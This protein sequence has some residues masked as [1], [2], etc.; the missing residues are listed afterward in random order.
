MWTVR[1]PLEGAIECDTLRDHG[2]KCDCVEMLSEHARTSP[3][4]Y[5]GA[6][7]DS[8]TVLTVIMA[9]EDVERAHKVLE[10]QTDLP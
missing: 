3:L 6:A 10:E 8:G 7:G 4:R 1:T 2:I 5:I 9:P